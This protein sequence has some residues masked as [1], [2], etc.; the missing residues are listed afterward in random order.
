[1]RS[2]VTSHRVQRTADIVRGK[3][4]SPSAIL[5][6]MIKLVAEDNVVYGASLVE[7]SRECC[8]R[9]YW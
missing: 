8:Q 2:S 9:G 3:G 1:M 6:V 5:A 7:M 4:Q